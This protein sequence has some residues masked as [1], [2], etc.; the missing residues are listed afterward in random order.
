MLFRSEFED[1]AVS[2]IFVPDVKGNKIRLV[3]AQSKNEQIMVTVE[4]GSDNWT[5][6][7]LT[8]GAEIQRS[9]NTVLM[10]RRS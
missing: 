10:E 6:R 7:F 1:G 9:E 8:G 5:C 3:T 4:G 2:K